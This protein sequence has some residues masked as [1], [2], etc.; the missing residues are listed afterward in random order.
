MERHNSVS[1]L[2]EN[3]TQKSALYSRKNS[4]NYYILLFILV[5]KKE[6]LPYCIAV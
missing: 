6:N 5:N 3:I 2:P 1:E 4:I